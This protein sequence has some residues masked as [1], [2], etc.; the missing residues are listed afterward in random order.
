MMR[1]R[2]SLT[3]AALVAASPAALAQSVTTNSATV[4]SVK[5]TGAKAAP[6]KS[7]LADALDSKASLINKLH[8]AHPILPTVTPPSPADD[9]HG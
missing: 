8:G 4:D 9:S 5:V 6:T 3:L 7:T 1:A 2:L